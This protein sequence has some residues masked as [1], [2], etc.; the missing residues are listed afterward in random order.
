MSANPIRDLFQLDPTVTFLNQGSF[1]ATPK[2]V[3]AVYQE[4]Q[5]VLEKQ[6]VAYFRAIDERLATARAALGAFLNTDGDNLVYVPNA[7]FGVNIVG[8]GMGLKAG[9]EILTTNHEYGACLNVFR[10]LEGK[11]GIKVVEAPVSLPAVDEEEYVEQIWSHRTDKTKLLFISH[12]TSATALRLPVEQLCARARAEGILSLVDGA[13]VIGQWPLDMTEVG[14]DFYTSNAHKWLC[15]PKGSAF[16]YAAPQHHSLLDPLVVGWG[17]GPERKKH[18]GSDFLDFHQYLG[19]NDFAAYLSVPAAI[20]F[21]QEHNWPS[22]RAR[23][24]EMVSEWVET[25]ADFTGLDPVY[26]DDAFYSQMAVAPLPE[27][28]DTIQLKADLYDH[29]RVEIPCVVWNDRPFIR[30]SLQGYNTQDDVDR[31]MEGLA[32]LLKRPG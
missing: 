13:H 23:C 14:A 17:W 7:T 28:T 29:F 24:H 27:G 31:L 25:M 3:M 19:T 1:G 12:V 16:L 9:D 15:S 6:P 10:F 21:H 8:Q 30:I 18:F 2:A 32:S 4:W 20:D 5:N 22:V 26:G 11:I